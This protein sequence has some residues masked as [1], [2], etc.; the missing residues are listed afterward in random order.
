VIAGAF[1]DAL[2]VELKTPFPRMSH[3]EA[4]AKYKSDKPDLRT[5]EHPW[6]FCWIT[7]F[8][9]FH[10][11]DKEK[12]WDP[13]HHPFTAPHPDDVGLLATDPGKMR[14]RAYDLVFNGLELGSGSIRI[15]D[16]NVQRQ[17]LRA[18][19]LPDAQIEDRF[20]FLLKALSYGAPP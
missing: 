13:E 20:G 4:M 2:G 7:E 3:A 17:L 5:P 16:P 6:A 8:P 19:G 1:R 11:N 14:S 15:H 18:I 10:W 12:R 9:L